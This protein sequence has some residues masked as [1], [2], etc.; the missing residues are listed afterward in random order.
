M[1]LMFPENSEGGSFMTRRAKKVLIT[2]AG[3][4]FLV[5]LFVPLPLSINSKD[6]EAAVSHAIKAVLGDRR[7]LTEKGF[8][9]GAGYRHLEET[10]FVKNAQVFFSNDLGIP[11]TIFLK[12][13]LR[14]VPTDRKTATGDGVVVVAF[15]NRDVH[16]RPA[17]HVQFAYVF[18]PNGAHGYE[19]K[20]YKSLATRYFVY[21]HQWIS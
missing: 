6:K 20:I 9:T 18:A 11:D 12:R 10:H 21:A 1:R 2:L 19:I 17:D 4:G 15:S 7:V 8:N 16:G 13:G 14:P 5:L 3:A